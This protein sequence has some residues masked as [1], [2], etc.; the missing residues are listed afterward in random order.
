MEPERAPRGG[1][2]PE[3]P[4]RRDAHW[5]AV[6]L[7]R[8][9]QHA[10]RGPRPAAHSRAAGA[11]A[12]AAR[13]APA[14]VPPAPA[15]V[16]APRAEPHLRSAPAP[17]APARRPRLALLAIPVLLVALLGELLWFAP[18]DQTASAPARSQP[19]PLAEVNPLGAHVFLEREVDP[20]KKEKTVQMVHDAGVRWMK[21]EFPWSELE[22]RPGVYYDE[23]N[24]KS[25]WAKFDDIVRLAAGQ[26][27]QVIARLDRAPD[28]ARRPGA[29]NFGAPPRDM[30]LFGDF[31]E[32]FVRHYNVDPQSPGAIHFLQIWNEPNLEREWDAGKT[33]SAGDYVALLRE[34]ATRARAVDPNI[35]ILS[36]PLATTNESAAANTPPGTHNER[37]TTYM[38]EMYD[39]GAAPY[40][41]VASANAFGYNSPPE[42]AP[43]ADAYNFRRVEL[44]RAVMEQHND[45]RTPVWIT[46]YA[47]DAPDTSVVAQSDILWGKVTLQQQADYTVR[48]IT[49]G[50]EHW[51]WVGVFVIWYFRQVGDRAPDSAE[52]YFGMVT[53]DFVTQPVYSAVKDEARR[54]AVA[55]PGTEGALG[56]AAQAGPGWGL[57]LTRADDPEQPT[58]PLL[59]SND[60]NATLDF[61]FRGTDLTVQL[62]P[63][64]PGD[65][66]TRLYVTVDGGAD[67]V[68][69]DVPRDSA[70]RPYVTQAQGGASAAP[71]AATGGRVAAPAEAPVSV[72]LVAGLGSEWAPVVHRATL[73]AAGAG[74]AVSGFTVESNRS[75]VAVSLVTALLLGALGLDL[76]LLWR[77]RR[78][79]TT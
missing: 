72:R 17:A 59:V 10:N 52:Y 47:W 13:P 15:P 5:G 4:I 36:A 77:A 67:R 8:G 68:A 40:F 55:G 20:F 45:A 34:A 46:E 1:A 12:G 56:A 9:E 57:R 49:Y 37:E 32:A 50:R 18:W 41:D 70:G 30:K 24:S 21:Q 23:K 39:A 65:G 7:S 61:T 75:Y 26:G 58:Q 31:V 48:G 79:R 25:S 3:S 51:P 27:L 14:P 38:A 73:K 35:V 54:L 22:F 29:N 19:L 69:P 6:S 62:P 71:A 11:P 43:S 2:S 66:D 60:A 28:W 74:A 42:E 44:L 78:P 63:A 76:F 64:G 33:V 53:P 16:N